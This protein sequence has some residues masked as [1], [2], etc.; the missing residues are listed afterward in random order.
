MAPNSRKLVACRRSDA[1]VR[2]DEALRPRRENDVQ[3]SGRS[4]RRRELAT[5]SQTKVASVET[6]DCSR[7]PRRSSVAIPRP[8]PRGV[9]GSVIAS[10]PTAWATTKR[11][12]VSDAELGKVGDERQAGIDSTTQPLPT[13]LRIALSIRRSDEGHHSVRRET[14]TAACE[15]TGATRRSNRNI[16]NYERSGRVGSTPVR[17]T[18]PCSP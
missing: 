15:G 18:N 5:T 17:W 9:G 3:T 4:R 12:H 6:A 11:G 14:S 16:Y 13:L 10:A 2:N 7:C 1:A 8:A